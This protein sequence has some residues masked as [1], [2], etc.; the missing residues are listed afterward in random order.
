MKVVSPQSPFD[1]YATTRSQKYLGVEYR[2]RDGRRLAGESA[3][4][5]DIALETTGT[6]CTWKGQLFCT[7]Y[8][9]VC[10][11]R[12]TPGKNVFTD[13]AEP[14]KSVECQWCQESEHYRW[15]AQ[16]SRTQASAVL[17]RYFDE[18]GKTFGRL[19]SVR[20]SRSQSPFI[21][22]FEV[23]DGRSRQIISST[24]LVRSFP[25]ATLR[26][27]KFEIKTDASRVIFE[28]RGHGHGAGLCQWGARGLAIAGRNFREILEYYYPGA[29]VVTL[30]TEAPSNG[31]RRMKEASRQ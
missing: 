4:S 27:P 23:S 16:V 10:G 24:A 31:Q 19:T 29:Q 11:G 18:S 13:A 20:P 3:N 21:P 6:V 8:S 7:Y 25:P 9:A 12:T 17:K 1:V 14:L 22:F 26:S 28:G 2:Q 30:A 5:R 15:T